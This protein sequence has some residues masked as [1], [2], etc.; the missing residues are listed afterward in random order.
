MF[1]SKRMKKV[2][3]LILTKDAEKVSKEVVKFGDFQ[4]IEIAADK[5][6]KYLLKKN[7]PNTM[8]SKYLE[9]ERRVN[10]LS[11]TFEN[12]LADLDS[13]NLTEKNEQLI[14]N[15]K[16]LDSIVKE[17]ETEL[18]TYNQERED[19][20][21]RKLDIEIKLKRTNIFSHLDIPWKKLEKLSYFTVGFGVVPTTSY[22]AFQ[23]AMSGIT[24]YIHH[25]DDIDSDKL[26][27]YVAPKSCKDKIEPIL[28]N[29]YFKD[30][31]LP[32]DLTENRK[33]AVLHY[34]F[35]LLAIHDEEIWLDKRL[36]DLTQKYLPILKLLKRSVQ[37]YIAMDKLHNEMASTQ[38]VALFS[39]WVPVDRVETIKKVVETVTTNH[40]VMVEQSAV[41]A[42]NQEGLTPPTKFNNPG[43]LKP[44]ESLVETFGIPNYREIDPTP[45]AAF[46]YVLMYGAMFGDVGH[47]IVL[48]LLG[49]L[50]S[51]I[52]AFKSV[53]NLTT[54]MA[55]IGVS[56]A[57]F[58]VLYG[59]I[60]GKETPFHPIWMR[61]LDHIMDI[62]MIAVVFGIVMIS[63]S[64]L[65][66]IINSFLEKNPGRLLFSPNGV[67]G[68]LFY[69]GVLGL[70]FCSISKISFPVYLWAIPIGAVLII[71]MEKTL[72]RLFFH[73]GGH[74]E[75]EE[76]PSLFLG[77]IE[78]F[79][80][81]IGFLSNTISFMRVGAFALN[82]GALMGVVFI[83]ADMGKG[84]G[85]VAEWLILL[86]GNMFVIGFEGF[87]VSIQVMRL[88]YYEFFVKFFRANGK[89]F[90]GVGI[91]KINN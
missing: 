81:I 60:F 32:Y 25:I 44:F 80:S 82:H 89:S 24:S 41:D 15:E 28:K 23:S 48:A 52:K 78:A 7:P 55:Y 5:A 88:E 87:I 51:N 34:A 56:S 21:T 12:Y 27:I 35:D 63:L 71:A 30:Y 54:I 6:K 14:L 74:H 76:K 77:F 90:D 49:L 29:V 43:I 22:N 45:I 59:E 2:D 17:I 13:G 68:L 50:L 39:G 10:F 11:S 79:E 40:C 57:L 61:P 18:N 37:Y 73:H 16:D 85:P 36:N 58:G 66:S 31:G 62:L 8:G 46:A 83:L 67:A 1:L 53:K 3:V 42:M 33:N 4:I 65:L 91:Y 9:Y 20:S 69:W 47:G 38:R 64:I 70:A 19:V 86:V 84:G 72:E 26:L 75:D